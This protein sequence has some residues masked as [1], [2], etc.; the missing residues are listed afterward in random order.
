M[1][2]LCVEYL[3]WSLRITHVFPTQP[4]LQH[5]SF[6][7][8]ATPFC[9]AIDRP[10]AHPSWCG[11]S[12]GACIRS[13]RP[14]QPYGATALDTHDTGEPSR[15]MVDRPSPTGSRKCAC[16]QH[17]HTAHGTMQDGAMWCD[18]HGLGVPSGCWDAYVGSSANRPCVEWFPCQ[19][20]QWFQE[21]RTLVVSE[22]GASGR[23]GA[24]GVVGGDTVVE[25]HRAVRGSYQVCSVQPLRHPPKTLVAHT[26]CPA[27]A[28][29]PPCANGD[30]HRVPWTTS[31]VQGDQFVYV[32]ANDFCFVLVYGWTL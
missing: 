14:R 16:M 3:F 2:C 32:G 18:L 22:V 5:C 7:P 19:L 30:Q 21:R 31:T 25:G 9:R 11:Y 15:G 4:C 10:E 28:K 29:P 13:L 26:A 6:W 12:Q 20:C 24:P 8:D 27:C 1:V 23:A 17:V